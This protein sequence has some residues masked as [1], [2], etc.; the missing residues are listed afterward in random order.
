MRTAIFAGVLML[1]LGGGIT[2]VTATSAA[3]VTQADCDGGGLLGGITSGLCRAVGTVGDV[4][5]GLTGTGA[6]PGPDGGGPGTAQET[7][8]DDARPSS[9][10]DTKAATDGAGNDGLL[11]KTLDDVCLPLVA[12]PECMGPSAIS[13][14]ERT[15]NAQ[16]TEKAE[17]PATRSRP[18]PSRTAEPEPEP[19]RDKAAPLPTE[20]LRP[21]EPR[22]RTA[23]MDDPVVPQPSPVIDAE[24][25]RVDL[26]WPGTAMQE[27]QRRMQELLKGTPPGERAVT[28]TRSSDTLGTVL[29]TILLIAAILAVRVLYTRRTGEE[30]IPL[31]PFKAGRHRTA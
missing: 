24:A 28:P 10:P 20:P 11:P 25:P 7:T 9:A 3:A 27:F 22:T 12:S 26:L 1:T 23:D 18:R 31:E 5:N 17:E 15:E 4:V 14:P 13:A 21:P 30:S 8:A 2:V 16:E 29:T 6:S 19:D